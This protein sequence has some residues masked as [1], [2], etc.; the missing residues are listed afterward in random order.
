MANTTLR[1]AALPIALTFILAAPLAT[2]AHAGD[3]STAKGHSALD[4]SLP[5]SL[6]GSLGGSMTISCDG[7]VDR[8]TRNA[9]RALNAQGGSGRASWTDNDGS[10][11]FAQRDGG[12]F[13][14]RVT[15]E[16]DKTVSLEMPWGVA[17]CLFGGGK[18]GPRTMSLASLQR[19]GGFSLRV[20]GEDASLNLQMK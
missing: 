20:N 4:L 15:D 19:N 10:R 2:P 8:E 6:L 11:L 17:Q 16:D 18:S 13:K 1:R 12:R 5:L 3:R 9:M 14:L 7:D